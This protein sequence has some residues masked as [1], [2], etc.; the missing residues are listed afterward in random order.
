MQLH[1]SNYIN[2]ITLHKC[3]YIYVVTFKQLHLC[4]YISTA[5]HFVA[6][7]KALYTCEQGI[8]H[9]TAQIHILTVVVGSIFCINKVGSEPYNYMQQITIK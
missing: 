9:I 2:A 3:N 8:I 7:I 5:A 1:L 4:N 6:S